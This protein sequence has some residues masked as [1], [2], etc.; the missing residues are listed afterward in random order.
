[1]Q[2]LQDAGC[3]RR[4]TTWFRPAG[5][6][7]T[8]WESECMEE[9]LPDRFARGTTSGALLRIGGAV[10][11]L[12]VGFFLLVALEA[13]GWETSSA[14]FA[15]LA[16]GLV[17]YCVT[18]WMSRHEVAL[19]PQALAP[20]RAFADELERERVTPSEERSS[21]ASD[22][23][24]FRAAGLA[25]DAEKQLAWGNEA[26]AAEKLTVI[27]TVGREEWLVGSSLAQRAAD[28]AELGKGP[29]G[30]RTRWRGASRSWD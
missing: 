3:T 21:G 20:I 8:M 26:A 19:A 15:A 27:G 10:A 6:S 30:R 25:E 18:T 16:G 7:F 12:F 24:L 5:G 17:V 9:H 14:M 11:L 1:M 22:D 13:M 23:S 28:L 29:T 4:A 2:L